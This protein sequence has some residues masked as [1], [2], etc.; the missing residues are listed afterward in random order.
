M[1]IEWMTS[2]F[3]A[4]KSR[5]MNNRENENSGSGAVGGIWKVYVMDATEIGVLVQGTVLRLL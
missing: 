1:R 4:W 3:W 5:A 2:E